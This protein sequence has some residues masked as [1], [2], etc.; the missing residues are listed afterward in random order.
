MNRAQPRGLR[1][2]AWSRI[3]DRDAVPG[4]CGLHQRH[5]PGN[6]RPN[7][8]IRRHGRVHRRA[9]SA[10][11]QPQSL[12]TADIGRP[13]T[14]GTYQVGDPFGIPTTITIPEGWKLDDVDQGRV[15][16]SSADPWI[17]I[18]I[19][20]NVFADPCQSAGG[21]IQPPVA[22]TVDAIV[23]SLTGMTGFTAGP[24]SDLDLG[25]HAGKAFDLQNAINTGSARCYQIDLLPMWTSRGGNE[26]WTIGGFKEH[27]WVVDVDGT[28]V[29]MDRGGAGVDEVA[30]SIRFGSPVA[31]TA[32]PPTPT[33]TGSRLSY[34]ALGDSLLFAAEEDCDGCTSAAVL[35]GQG[36]ETDLGIPV[37]VHNLTMH[38]GLT[39]PMLL[40][41][42]ERGVKLGRDPEDLFTAVAAAD[43]ISLTIGFNDASTPDPNS[44]PGL[45]TR[46]EA[47]LDGILSRI[48]ELRGGKPT[49]IRVTNI[50]NNGGAAWTEVVQAM[51]DVACEVA[52]RHN[53]DCVDIYGP[54]MGPDGLGPID[55]GY[56]GP[57]TTHP[58]QRGMEVIADALFEAGYAPL[59]EVLAGMGATP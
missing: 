12:G 4:G 22:P 16:F 43:I 33:P 51:N 11:A 47:D 50:Y 21:P 46:Y 45:R 48:A 19:L 39:S 14:A 42:F 8:R 28:P 15:Y 36:M 37:D 25:E 52:V 31:W 30:E 40:D 26:E 24:V 2:T 35:Y 17:V 34:V 5:R 54:F 10:T 3:T 44:I 23:A 41:Y 7:R 27:M 57:D 20:E 55:A 53:A 59:D 58:S 29:V 9:P 6:S 13:L 38:N 56:L 49:A 18:D 1:P 32:P